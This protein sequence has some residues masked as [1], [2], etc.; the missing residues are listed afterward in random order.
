MIKLLNF[1]DN[2]RTIVPSLQ[3]NKIR[4]H[5]QLKIYEPFDR[6]TKIRPSYEQ[7]P[8]EIQTGTYQIPRNWQLTR[9]LN[10]DNYCFVLIHR[11][12]C[13]NLNLLTTLTQKLWHNNVIW[14]LSSSKGNKKTELSCH[15]C[16]FQPGNPWIG[17]FKE[18]FQ[19]VYAEIPKE[20]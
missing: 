12:L 3:K 15:M 1:P 7:I 10:N 13:D 4:W 18:M 2:W 5:D 20:N 6:A 9:E 17:S 19:V 8:E 14:D 16:V 11:T